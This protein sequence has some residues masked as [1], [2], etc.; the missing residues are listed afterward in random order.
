MAV[1]SSSVSSIVRSS[2][3][4][5]LMTDTTASTDVCFGRGRSASRSRRVTSAA[6]H[7]CILALGGVQA[8]AHSFRQRLAVQ[9]G[10]HRD[11]ADIALGHVEVWILDNDIAVEH[12]NQVIHG[13]HDQRVDR[14]RG[15]RSHAHTMGRGGDHGIRHITQSPGPC[16]RLGFSARATYLIAHHMPLESTGSV[17]SNPIQVNLEALL[18][19]DGLRLVVR[20]QPEAARPTS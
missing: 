5:R 7:R 15:T 9:A 3:R 8:A 4:P 1:E 16:T 12:T 19:S 10:V 11:A 6:S 14:T 2:V 18:R 13:S 17:R 20:D